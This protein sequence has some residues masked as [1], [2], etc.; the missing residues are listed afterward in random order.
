MVKIE[1]ASATATPLWLLLSVIVSLLLRVVLS[2]GETVHPPEP[3]MRVTWLKPTEAGQTKRFGDKLIFYEFRADWCTPCKQMEKSAFYSKD[4]VSMLNDRFVS[5]QVTDRKREN[6]KNDDATQ[7]L[8]DKFSIQAFPSLVVAMSDGTKI[9][10]HLGQANSAAMKKFLQEAETLADYYNGKEKIIAGDNAAAASAFDRFLSAT[11]WQHWRCCYTA[12]FGSIAHRELGNSE[13][14]EQTLKTALVQI[15]EHTF[16]YPILEYL[17][18]KR[19]FDDLL[20]DASENKS[21]RTLCYAYAG[22]DNYARK[23]YDLAK[24]LFEWVL[25]NCDDKESFEYRVSQAK[26]QQMSKLKN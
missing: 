8:E 5:V 7:T 14:A 19:S 3:S 11:K 12:I 15:R 4:I 1:T 18:A 21:N 23:K 13:K 22:M 17:A 24:P 16:P 25:E 2:L 26:L 10:D 20:K 9:I 6:G